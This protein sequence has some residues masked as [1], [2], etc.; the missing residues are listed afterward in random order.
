MAKLDRRR[1]IEHETDVVWGHTHKQVKNG[2]VHTRKPSACE[3][4]IHA[5]AFD[6]EKALLCDEVHKASG[7]SSA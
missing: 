1:W 6:D 5:K 2:Q 3:K 4:S 7:E